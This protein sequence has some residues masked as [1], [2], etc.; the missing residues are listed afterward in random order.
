MG[1]NGEEEIIKRPESYFLDELEKKVN[2]QDNIQISDVI[3]SYKLKVWKE[4]KFCSSMNLSFSL[5]DEERKQSKQ[6]F[7]IMII[8]FLFFSLSKPQNES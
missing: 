4:K 7:T 1:I 2:E 6:S 3:L 8:Q 5:K